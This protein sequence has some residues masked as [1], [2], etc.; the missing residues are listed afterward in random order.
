[1]PCAAG[2][3]GT[4]G[5]PEKKQ[6]GGLELIN[7]NDI[8]IEKKVVFKRKINVKMMDFAAKKGRYFLQR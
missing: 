8:K 7:N 6:R 5:T 2:T 1:V 3:L 4:V